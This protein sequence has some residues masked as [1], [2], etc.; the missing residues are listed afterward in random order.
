MACGA[1]EIGDAEA[2]SCQMLWQR[3]TEDSRSL[4]TAVGTVSSTCGRVRAA[5]PFETAFRLEGV[6]SASAPEG[7]RESLV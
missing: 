2:G 5:R 4:G 6:D 1:A 7:A 3:G